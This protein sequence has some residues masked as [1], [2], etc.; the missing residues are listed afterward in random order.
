MAQACRESWEVLR[1]SHQ[2]VQFRCLIGDRLST[3]RWISYSSTIFYLGLIAL[4]N[5][6]E[7]QSVL[8]QLGSSVQH[9]AMRLN[10]RDYCGLTEFIKRFK[11]FPDLRTLDVLVPSRSES[12]DFLRSND[13]LR[14]LGQLINWTGR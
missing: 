4:D 6:W 1:I 13:D 10:I 3:Y 12:L 9:L 7:W 14:R 2:R 11:I 8:S 5:R